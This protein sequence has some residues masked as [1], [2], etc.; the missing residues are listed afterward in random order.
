[1]GAQDKVLVRITGRA[2]AMNE[3][4]FHR[5]RWL[6]GFYFAMSVVMVAFALLFAV[7]ALGNAVENTPWRGKTWGVV[8]W[9]V[10][11]LSWGMGTIQMWQM[12]RAYARSYVAIGSD[13]L[14]IRVSSDEGEIRIPLGDILHVSH[15]RTLRFNTCKVSTTDARY[16][17][18][19]D[20]CSH[21][22]KIAALVAERT[23]KPLEAET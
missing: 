8:G 16:K 20:N 5:S 9:T 12:G 11:A 15:K 3:I 10:G 13:A 23:G 7:V 17:L 21:P 22:E 6:S 19:K 14:R 18:T 4:V 1:M 2:A